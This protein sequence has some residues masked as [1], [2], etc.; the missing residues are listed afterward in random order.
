MSAPHILT[1]ILRY[2]IPVDD[3]WHTLPIGG[4]IVHVGT[5]HADIVEIWVRDFQHAAH[6]LHRTFRVFATGQPIEGVTGF[7][8]IHRGSAI[9]PGGAFVW[10]LFE[11]VISDD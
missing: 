9:T 1:R 2:E 8:P 5:R 11:K 6:Q 10:H 4:Q 3:Q 7:S